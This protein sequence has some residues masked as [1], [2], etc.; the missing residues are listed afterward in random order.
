MK[1]KRRASVAALVAFLILLG[2]G[3][4]RKLPPMPPGAPDPVEIQSIEFVNGAVEA[5]VKCN[6]PGGT[7]ALLGKPKGLCPACTDDLVEKDGKAVSEKGTVLLRD[8]DPGAEYMIYRISFE[9]DKTT[10]LTGHR[11]VRK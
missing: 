11:V 3:C 5:S 9:K 10:W 4:G 1:S 8:P 2:A 6:V 7:V